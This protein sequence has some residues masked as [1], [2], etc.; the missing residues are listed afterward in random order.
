MEQPVT[1]I[2]NYIKNIKKLSQINYYDAVYVG[3]AI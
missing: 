1:C 3:N 2:K